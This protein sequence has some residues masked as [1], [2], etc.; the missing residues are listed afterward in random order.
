MKILQ[1][2]DSN[3]KRME[4]QSVL[5]RMGI[6]GSLWVRSVEE[7]IAAAQQAIEEGAPFDAA[8]TDMHYPVLVG[9]PAELKAG[10]VF[11]ERL[12]EQEIQL[13][14]IVFSTSRLVEE[15]AFATIWYDER[16]NWEYDLQMTLQKIRRK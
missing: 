11:I 5:K 9:G 12:K 7:G 16:S 8:I 13:P 3:S 1:L 4:I 6:R 15:D 14:V 2:D 10:R